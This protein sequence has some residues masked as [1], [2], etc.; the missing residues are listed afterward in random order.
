MRLD[1]H[2]FTL[3]EVLIATIVLAGMGAI[4]FGTFVT[5]RLWVVNGSESTPVNLARER[6]EELQM[7]VR[8]DTWNAGDLKV[9]A[10]AWTAEPAI[11]LEGTSYTR[12]TRVSAIPARQYRKVEAKV[13]W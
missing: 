2:G 6:L 11:V 5:A 12:R 8:Q 1:R 7:S 3:L 4:L 13:E 9:S 10:P